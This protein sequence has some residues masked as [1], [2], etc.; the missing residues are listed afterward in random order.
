MKFEQRLT[1]RRMLGASAFVGGLAMLSPGR[2][3]LA[4]TTPDPFI[5]R[6]GKGTAM[7]RPVPYSPTQVWNYNG[8]CLLYTSDAADE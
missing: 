4:A 2:L 1:R 5:L 7:L 8:T 3:A 6:A